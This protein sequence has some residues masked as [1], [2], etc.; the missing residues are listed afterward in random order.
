MGLYAM[1]SQV[2]LDGCGGKEIM[3]VQD[4][5]KVTSDDNCKNGWRKVKLQVFEHVKK[6]T[7]GLDGRR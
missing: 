7:R 2:G 1:K 3:Q 5:V 4:P 6:E